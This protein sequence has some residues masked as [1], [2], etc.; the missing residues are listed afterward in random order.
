MMPHSCACL[1]EM[2]L[3]IAAQF[4]RVHD[5]RQSRQPLRAR[6]AGNQPE[7]H[8]R[9]THLRVR[10]SD[11]VM[12]GLRQLQAAAE[13]RAVNRADDGFRTVLDDRE[14]RV[15][16]LVAFLLAGGDLAEL[17]D[18]S[19]RDECAA[20]ADQHDRF[21][22]RVGAGRLH[23]F[24]HPFGDARAQ[25]VNGRIVDRHDR[26]VTVLGKRYQVTHGA[27]P[28]L[29]IGFFVKRVESLYKWI[30]RDAIDFDLVA[31]PGLE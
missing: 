8:L 28:F 6:T 26:D 3:P 20:A 9:L 16:T 12:A 14:H 17:L 11:A 21:D 19:P 23:V 29:S 31:R 15:Q 24:D 10:H 2:G 7:L 18:V 1:A 13:G 25:R 5:S 27:D 30:D 22:R 4:G